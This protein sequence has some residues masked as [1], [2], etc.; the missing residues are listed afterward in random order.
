MN[1]ESYKKYFVK[2][3]KYDRR[4]INKTNLL[5]KISNINEST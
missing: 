1:L 3:T 4:Q 5:P 2:N